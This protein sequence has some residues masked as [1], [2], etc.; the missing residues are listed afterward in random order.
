MDWKTEFNK[1]MTDRYGEYWSENVEFRHIKQ[2]KN[3]FRAGYNAAV[4]NKII[5]PEER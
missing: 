1:Y 3:I 5:K 2:A 4:R